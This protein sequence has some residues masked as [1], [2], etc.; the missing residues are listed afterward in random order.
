MYS[1][2]KDMTKIL[3]NA[4]QKF[5]FKDN[6]DFTQFIHEIIER[7]HLQLDWDTGAGEEWARLIADNF[8][9]VGMVHTKIGIAFI[10]KNYDGVP[11][12]E[13][14]N[15]LWC[16]EVE[17]YSAEEWKIDLTTVRHQLAE[18]VWH[19]SNDVVNSNQFSLNDFYFTTV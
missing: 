16:E 1:K 13:L 7:T 4:K 18:I 19:S 14:M 8:G 5:V 6:K 2:I 9:I 10:R 3:L 17:N 11:L 15:D 12:K